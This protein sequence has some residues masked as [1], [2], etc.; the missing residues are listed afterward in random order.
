MMLMDISTALA[1][2]G[3]AS[4]LYFHNNTCSWLIARS[5]IRAVA[6]AKGV[7][8]LLTNVAT[9]ISYLST[10]RIDFYRQLLLSFRPGDGRFGQLQRDR[11]VEL[12]HFSRRTLR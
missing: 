9:S 2:C 12:P 6:V 8:R 7:A 11:I 5:Q 10:N 4:S 1:Q 3:K